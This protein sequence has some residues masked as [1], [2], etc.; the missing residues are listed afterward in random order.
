MRAGDIRAA[1]RYATAL[2]RMAVNRQQIDDVAGSIAEIRTVTNGS[3]ELM[4][5]LH[6][7]RITRAR[8]KQ[9]LQ[10]VFEGKIRQ[11]VTNFLSLVIEKDRAALIPAITEE[12]ARLMDEHRRETDA[13]AVSA[14]ALTEAQTAALKQRLESS[15]GYTVRLK[16][17]VDLEIIGGLV[18]RVGDKLMDGSVRTQLQSLRDQLKRARIE[19]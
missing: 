9:L 4:A 6:H 18:V 19:F 11:D 8:K 16:T 1:R 10:T 15:T 2:F 12:F 13:E 17:R 3:P 14:I 7:P 5:V